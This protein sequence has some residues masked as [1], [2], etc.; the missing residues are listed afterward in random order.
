MNGIA[1]RLLVSSAAI[2]VASLAL[3]LPFQ[4]GPLTAPSALA[5]GSLPACRYDDILTAPRLYGDW[6]ATLVDPILRIPSTYVPPDLVSTSAAGLSG[7]GLVRAVAIDDLKAMGDA[8]R[9]AGAPISVESAYRSYAQ[10]RITFQDWVNALGYAQ[11]LTVSARPGHSEHQLGLAIDFKSE[12]G[13]A[14][15]N[16]ADWATTPA[17]AWMHA[18]AWQYGWILSY[19]RNSLNIVCYA[20]EP[21]HYR[22]V[23]RDLAAQIHASGLT[24]RAY[25]WRT[26]TTAVVGPPSGGSAGPTPPAPSRRPIETPLSSAPPPT[27]QPAA[28]SFQA[29]AEPAATAAV[30]SPDPSLAAAATAPASAGFASPGALGLLAVFVGV[31]VVV[32][33]LV[34]ASRSR[35]AP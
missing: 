5:M 20:Y 29:S 1:R 12:P 26:F 11:A 19:P 18:H 25:L 8:A 32:G 27:A 21:W 28:T 14:P 10:Q 2:V 22:Y 3:V 23:G 13:S 6:R 4:L 9:A 35:R 15:W 31:V 16:G 30:P 7:G 34:A 24:T 33:G 17:G